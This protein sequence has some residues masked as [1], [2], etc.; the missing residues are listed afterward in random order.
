MLKVTHTHPSY[1]PQ[2]VEFEYDAN[3]NMLNDEQG[4]SLQYD[5]QGRAWLLSAID[6][7]LP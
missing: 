6:M 5:S 7:A 1:L 3:G 4:R 2:S